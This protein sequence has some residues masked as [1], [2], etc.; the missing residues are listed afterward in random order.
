MSKPKPNSEPEIV[1][2]EEPVLLSNR[3]ILPTATGVISTNLEPDPVIQEGRN[4]L[5]SALKEARN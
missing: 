1:R 2:R 4:G 5:E 3:D